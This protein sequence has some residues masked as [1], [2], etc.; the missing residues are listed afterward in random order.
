MTSFDLII[1]NGMV[2]DGSGNGSQEAD[3]GVKNGRI[4]EVGRLP[5]QSAA[6]VLEAAGKTVA[7]GFIDIHTHTD[8]GIHGD[9]TGENY[10]RQ[11]VTT[12]LGGNCG[13]LRL[14]GGGGDGAGP[15]LAA[16]LRG[17]EGRI[18][19]NFG[20]LM[21]FGTL[22]QACMADPTL[23]RPD[24]G[25]LAA[26]RD[27]MESSMR[28]G[29]FGLSLGLEYIPDRFATAD[30]IVEMA[31]IVANNHG[32]L[33]THMRDEQ[34]GVLAS[35]GEVIEIARKSGVS[36]EVSHLK[37]CG[38]AVWGYGK[39][40]VAMLTLARAMG[41]DV[42]ADQYPYAAA[43]TGLGQIFPNWAL[44]GG[45]KALKKR[46]GNPALQAR[47]RAYGAHQ[48]KIRVGDNPR[49][50]QVASY[51][52]NSAWE[53]KTMGD[54]LVSLGKEPSMEH[55]LDLA[56]EMYLTE[57]P[58][59]I[60]HYMD[61][62]D[63]QTIM[64]SPYVCVCSDGDIRRYGAG[65][66]HPRSYGSFPRVLGRYARERYVIS[67]E[68]AIRKMT[69]LPAAKMKLSDRGLLREGYWADIVIYDDA[70][71]MDTA[72]FL[73]PHQYP[74]GIEYVLVNGRIAVHRGQRLDTTGGTVLY[75][76]AYGG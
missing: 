62:E 73:N 20:V 25:Q 67:P 44:E 54:I 75:G 14:G 66:P 21:G 28:E 15:G 60:Y 55:L 7:P 72:D 53:G 29:A 16:C 64:A 59:I 65:A 32:I 41:V 8:V 37:A 6:T 42:H 45:L 22:R 36:L 48:L 63:I 76:P 19:L 58:N 71:I 70:E 10:I 61:E 9:P 2:A 5:G 43:N 46:L 74:A 33:A 34:T 51:P 12:V 40:L 18:G 49:L 47:I 69:S 68:E 11:G 39:T 24:A 57:N 35:L 27:Y 50:I 30:E 52:P 38:A 23:P 4:A 31:K 17:L 3:I 13:G 26:M 56:T 1:K